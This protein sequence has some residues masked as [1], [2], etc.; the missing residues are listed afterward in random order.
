MNTSFD[1]SLR[2]L[3]TGRE[4][5]LALKTYGPLSQRSLRY[6]L[7]NSTAGK[8]KEALKRLHKLELIQSI[9]YRYEEK[10][11]VY[12]YIASRFDK[13]F[14]IADMLGCHAD[15]LKLECLRHVELPHE[16]RCARVHFDL[17]KM[18]PATKSYRD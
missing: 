18:F 17:V 5:L 14:L 16:Q 11:G 9:S 1:K 7:G 3:K 15:D 8:M 2:Q 13:R 6:I 4:I 12:Y 10:L